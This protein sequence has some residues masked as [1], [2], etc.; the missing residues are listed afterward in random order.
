MAE[1]TC[2]PDVVFLNQMIV[3][4]FLVTFKKFLTAE[5]KCGYTISHGQWCFDR[6]SPDIHFLLTVEW[7]VM[8]YR[9]HGHSLSRE[10]MIFY[11][12]ISFCLESCFA[13][14]S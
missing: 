4:V 14:K 9:T 6:H 12:K 13:S 7:P 3:F 1:S 11:K 8:L 5:E 10:W 2:V